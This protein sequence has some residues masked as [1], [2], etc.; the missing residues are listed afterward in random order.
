[1]SAS[2]EYRAVATIVKTHGRRGEVV[3]EPR[4]GLPLLLERG[5]RVALVPPALK[6]PR[7]LVVASCANSNT[8]QL[9]AFEGVG[10]LA[11]ADA[12]VGCT[13]L[14]RVDD[15]P[16]DFAAHD[17]EALIG[18]EVFDVAFGT[19]GDIREVLRGPANDVWVIEGAFGE[20]LIPVVEHVVLEV[21]NSGPIT[22]AVPT[23]LMDG[24]NE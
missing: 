12:L 7:R 22:C 15:L 2:W 1:M 14:M 24:T 3:A 16:A 9:V 10:D 21:P 4:H 19:L 23:G 20:V 13:V 17:I 6:G 11:S 18:R 8:G 5:V